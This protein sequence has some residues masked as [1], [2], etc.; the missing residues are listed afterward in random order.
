M[1]SVS[2]EPPAAPPASRSMAGEDGA[3]LDKLGRRLVLPLLLALLAYA[4]LVLFAD[5]RLL[6]ERVATFELALLLPVLALSLVNYGLRFLRWQR[7][8]RALEVSIGIGASLAVFLVGFLL[9]ITPGKA[10]ELGKAWLVRELA[11]VPARRVVPAVLAERLTDLFAVVLL[12]AMGA[13]AFP[14]G[15]LLALGGGGFVLL[16]LGLLAWQRAVHVLLGRAARWRPL[17][18]HLHLLAE[19][20]DRLRRLLAPRQ[21]LPALA[22]G[23]VAWGA[24]GL[25]FWL[26]V[27]AFE[28]RASWLAAVFDYNL[29]SL[30]GG[31]SLLP[32]GLLAAEGAL[33]G[34]LGAQGHGAAAA[35]SAVLIIRAATLWFA[36]G[37][38]FAALPFVWR[39]RRRA[40]RAGR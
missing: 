37:L 10:G 29:S 1:N 5:A 8:L 17:A 19:I 20:Y 31:L 2:A 16:A 6:A 3:A 27:R 36:V 32:G 38:G 18:A 23:V 13:L 35:A 24:E 25:G 12:V 40:S 14:G 11:D 39:L 21:L 4:G 9:S 7:Y 22:L 26:V 28:P 15:R 33:A 34:L 30:A